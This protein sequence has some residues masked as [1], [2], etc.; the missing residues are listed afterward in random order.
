MLFVENKAVLNQNSPLY[1]Y[2]PERAKLLSQKYAIKSNLR[3][4]FQNEPE[5]LGPAFHP[6]VNLSRIGSLDFRNLIY[7]TLVH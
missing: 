3:K 1:K 6:N 2:S 5:N 4:E 7:S